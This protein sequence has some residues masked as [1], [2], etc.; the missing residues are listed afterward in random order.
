M[1]PDL[2]VFGKALGNGY[3]I[4]AVLGTKDIMKKSQ[5]T[6]IS[7]S[8]FTDR[9]G[10]VAALA[11]LKKMDEI[12]SYERVSQY[13]DYFRNEILKL[14]EEFDLKV[15]VTGMR[16]LTSI[17]IED[18]PLKFKTFVTEEMLKRGYLFSNL[19]YASVLHTPDI[20]DE[21]VRNIR[22]VL[23]HQRE[24]K[25]N[26]SGEYFWGTICHSTFERIN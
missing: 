2:C 7:S 25:L 23:T 11:T 1:Q 17:S 21:C 14:F 20:I 10:F 18:E 6:F 9:I 8:Y 5:S 26:N 13:G 22:S 16:A 3:P 19:F 12:S 24:L 4:T 15:Q